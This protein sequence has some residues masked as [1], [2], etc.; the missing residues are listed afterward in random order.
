[1][2][3]VYAFASELERVPPMPG[4]ENSPLGARSF[5][6]IVAV[7]S[8]HA[9][10]LDTPAR[11]DIVRHGEV[12]AA[13]LD[14]AG[15]VLPARFG[16]DFADDAAFEAAVTPKLPA[17]RRRLGEVANHVEV[18]LRVLDTVT[19]APVRQEGG[20]AEYLRALVPSVQRRDL[21]A[22]ELHEPVAALAT[23]HRLSPALDRSS[24]HTGAYLVP[25]DD[26]P[27][28]TEIVERFADAHPDL[29]VLCT[30]PWAPYSFAEAS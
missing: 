22:S 27:V 25:G 10:R 12:V 14:S 17:L 13:L 21:V 28:V 7:T 1:M 19:D 26:V 24:L 29:T 23:A 20:G 2:I 9:T 4:I 30:G 3:H 18:G 15:S 16:E 6:D 5:G 11:S 8:F